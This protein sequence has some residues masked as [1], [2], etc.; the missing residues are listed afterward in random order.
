MQRPSF[1]LSF[2]APTGSSSSSHPLEEES[3]LPHSPP[4]FFQSAPAY[5]FLA[6]S[7]GMEPMPHAVEAWS[8]NHWTTPSS[9]FVCYTLQLISLSLGVRARPRGWGCCVP[10][11]PLTWDRCRGWGWGSSRTRVGWGVGRGLDLAQGAPH[12]G[13]PA[14]FSGSAL[15]PLPTIT[16]S[17]L[18][19]S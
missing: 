5:G 17:H 9:L 2:L 15:G 13:D 16:A 7:P 10:G 1:L 18:H 6:S 4:F 12:P 3:L 11:S 8:L 19:P 14:P